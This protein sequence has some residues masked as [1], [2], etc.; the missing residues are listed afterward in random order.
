M[1]KSL[2]LAGLKRYDEA[3]AT[4]DRSLA[5]RPDN[6]DALINRGYYLLSLSR[7]QEA[8]ATLDRA[9]VLAPDDATA[10]LN[11]GL[12]LEYLGRYDDALAT[13]ERS[14][15]LH[16]DNLKLLHFKA[17]TLGGLKRFSDELA[18]LDRALLVQ[19]DDSTALYMM[20]LVF[21]DRL[22]RPGDARAIL[23]RVG[24]PNRDDPVALNSHGWL[25]MR[26]EHYDEGLMDVERSLAIRPGDRPTLNSR[27]YALVGLG[28]YQEALVDATD[29]MGNGQDAWNKYV[30][31]AAYAGMGRYGE[32]MSNLR[33]AVA[34]DDL[35]RREAR[36]SDWFD[37]LR[38]DQRYG[39]RFTALIGG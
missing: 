14:L 16:P 22:D 4:V 36:N 11:R 27:A 18:T 24:A 37:S 9:L 25:L 33:W 3:L 10:L 38:R 21:L 34:Q 35:F 28:R 32:S 31:A 5:L 1:S 13:Y 26:L 29:S 7:Y 17:R 8:L 19:P 15:A 23:A 12:V 6:I 39:P 30:L 2:A 20:G